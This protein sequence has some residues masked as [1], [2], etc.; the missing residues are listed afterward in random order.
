MGT[1]LVAVGTRG[2]GDEYV[3]VIEELIHS[4]LFINDDLIQGGGSRYPP[5]DIPTSPSPPGRDC[6]A[7][8]RPWI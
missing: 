1:R 8:E 3:E 2:R 6:G 4:F 5:V 7:S